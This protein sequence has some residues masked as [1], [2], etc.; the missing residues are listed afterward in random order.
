MALK[1]ASTD[2][3]AQI[4]LSRA[5]LAGPFAAYRELV[6]VDAS[7]EPSG[8]VN[9]NARK[10]MGGDLVDSSNLKAILQAP[11]KLTQRLNDAGIT[12]FLDAQ[13]DP[14][15][16]IVYDT[17]EQ[18]GHLTAHTSLAQFFDPD[19]VVRADGSPDY[20]GWS[21]AQSSG[22]NTTRMTR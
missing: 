11:E 1:R 6:G 20:V 4:G 13:A 21:R 14:D 10:L 7:G 18:R 16:F 19:V 12:A 22:A 17:L 15:N 5:T 9:E 3:G 2:K 8:G